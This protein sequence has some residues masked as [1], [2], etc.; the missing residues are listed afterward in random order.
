MTAV[1]EG[2][3]LFAESIDWSSDNRLRKDSRRTNFF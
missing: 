3:S 2:A 1:A